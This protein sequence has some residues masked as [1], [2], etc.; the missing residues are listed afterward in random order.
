MGEGLLYPQYK[1][2]YDLPLSFQMVSSLQGPWV[3]LTY[4]RKETYL[5][6][7]RAMFICLFSTVCA[8]GD[9]I[10]LMELEDKALWS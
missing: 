10:E 6:A 3:C 8:T 4:G 5:C 7:T 1:K 9:T 2:I